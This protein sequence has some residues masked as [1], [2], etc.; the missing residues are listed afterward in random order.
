VSVFRRWGHGA[1]FPVTFQY[2]ATGRRTLKTI[3]SLTTDFLH[4]G[5]TPVTE[6]APGLHDRLSL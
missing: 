6:S 4:D 2:D 3:N 5:I 1:Q